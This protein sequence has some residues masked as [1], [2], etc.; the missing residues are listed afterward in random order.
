[1]AP[2]SGASV[3]DPLHA[4]ARTALLLWAALRQAIAETTPGMCW[5]CK[6]KGLRLLRLWTGIWCL[7]QRARAVDWGAPS[8][9]RHLPLPCLRRFTRLQAVEVVP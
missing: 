4:V 6:A 1:M 5:P 8:R 3:F 2:I 7:S 9:R